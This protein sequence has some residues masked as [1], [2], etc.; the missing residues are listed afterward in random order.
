M[1]YLDCMVCEGDIRE[2]SRLK[3]VLGEGGMAWHFSF[4]SNQP[5]L[6]KCSFFPLLTARTLKLLRLCTSVASN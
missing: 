1:A 4:I 2:V 5:I 6:Q 3:F